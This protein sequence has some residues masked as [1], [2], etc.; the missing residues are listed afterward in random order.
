MAKN[1]YTL[2]GV[3]KTATEAEIKKAYRALAKK[4][5]PD[6]NPG[7]KAAETKFKEVTAA[8]NLLSNK[9]LREQYDSGQVDASGQQQNPFGAG[10]FGGFNQGGFQRTSGGQDEMADLFASLFG[11]NMG[12][13]NPNRGGF[14][15]AR[16]RP[17]KGADI[18][19]SLQISFIDSLTGGTKNVKIGAGKPLSLKI[20]VGVEDGTTLR[21]RGKGQPGVNGGPAGDAKI[22]IEVGTHKHLRR[23]GKNLRLALPISLK[24]AIL[25][26]KIK[27][28][29]PGGSVQL[30]LP[31]GTN[32]GKTF[33]LKGKGVKGGDL[34]VKTQIVL[35][36]PKNKALIDWAKGDE[37]ENDFNP[38]E[39]IL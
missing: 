23:E 39:N 6:V 8:Y 18:R 4:L 13:M 11:M 7:D 27:V 32:S 15:Q 38:R 30:T 33:R 12:G 1:P 25:G 10:G 31:A 34:L 24:E 21:L 29:M 28:L 26:G 19:A 20:P 14:R 35:K 2:L 36:D 22:D 3:S 5:H 17:Q 16:P 37:S 9:E